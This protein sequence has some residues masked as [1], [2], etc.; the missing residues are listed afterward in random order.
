MTSPRR[1]RPDVQ[2]TNL[3]DTIRALRAKKRDWGSEDF[4]LLQEAPGI[5]PKV[6]AYI[7]QVKQE[8]AQG[9]LK[10][11]PAVDPRVP[12][13]REPGEDDDV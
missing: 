12:R 8:E 2:P 13:E 1:I 7:E 11:H 3:L 4:R 6:K 5:G 9:R 10:R